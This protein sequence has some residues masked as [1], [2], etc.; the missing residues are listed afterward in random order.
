MKALHIDARPLAAALHDGIMLMVAC[1]GATWLLAPAGALPIDVLLGAGANPNAA[2]PDGRTPR[3]LAR[4]HEHERA[5]QALQR[6]M[7]QRT[8][9]K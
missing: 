1:V 6:A 8:Q 9:A 7:A 5:V 2:M 3:V 4:A